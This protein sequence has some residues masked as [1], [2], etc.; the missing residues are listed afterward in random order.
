MTVRASFLAVMVKPRGKECFVTTGP[1]QGDPLGFFSIF[2]GHCCTASNSFALAQLEGA[3]AT[4]TRE[5][6]RER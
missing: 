4:P 6:K 2:T 5:H 1:S 3:S